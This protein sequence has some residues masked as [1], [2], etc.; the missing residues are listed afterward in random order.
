MNNAQVYV[1]MLAKFCNKTS[2]E[3][4]K[5]LPFSALSSLLFVCFFLSLCLSGRE[6]T[7]QRKEGLWPTYWL[8]W[9]FSSSQLLGAN[10]ATEQVWEDIDRP[11]YLT[12]QAAVDYGL[13]DH[14][15]STGDARIEKKDY[16][17]IL[18]AAQR[19]Q[20]DIIPQG[21]SGMHGGY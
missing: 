16:D 13:I 8:S 3:V 17:A 12:P 6:R 18:A 14:V 15:L 2:E 19:A 4:Y 1:D 10:D 20:G 11:K 5:L 21:G 9:Q 7:S